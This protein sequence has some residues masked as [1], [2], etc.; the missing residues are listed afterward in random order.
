VV[1][2]CKLCGCSGWIFW[3]GPDGLCRNCSNIAG[4]DM[5]QRASLAQ[6]ARQA[7]E[8]TLNPHSKIAKLDL[9]VSELRALA[10]Y[11]QKGIKTP[12]EAAE[13]KLHKTEADRDALILRT[14]REEA[15][16]TMERVGGADGTEAK[17]K[18]LDELRLRLHEYHGRCGDSPSIEILEKR[19][20]TSAYRIRLS[21]RLDAARTAE[22]DADPEGAKR[23]YAE[24]LDCLDREGKTDPSYRKQRDRINKQIRQLSR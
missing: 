7:A 8:S 21:A 3:T 17:L 11:E 19:V 12:V 5:R 13:M 4:N 24:A 15:L 23:L 16:Q 9:A 1:D 2:D 6:S 20:R 14:A 22:K 18:L 10:G